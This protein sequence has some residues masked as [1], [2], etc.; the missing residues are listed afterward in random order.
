M[1]SLDKFSQKRMASFLITSFSFT[2]INT[3]SLFIFFYGR[4]GKRGGRG[5]E[6]QFL[7]FGELTLPP[8][9]LVSVT[10][11]LIEKKK[12]LGKQELYI[13]W[14][15]NPSS[16]LCLTLKCINL[17]VFLCFCLCEG[18]ALNHIHDNAVNMVK[19]CLFF[20]II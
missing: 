6:L 5:Q 18:E 1:I 20:R 11:Y 2:S 4:R 17:L 19:F 13:L 3:N 14:V 10:I 15:G 8:I 9:T 16:C 7:V 12:L